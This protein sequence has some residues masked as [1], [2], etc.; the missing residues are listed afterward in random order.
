MKAATAYFGLRRHVAWMKSARELTREKLQSDLPFVYASHRTPMLRRLSGLDMR[1]QE[2]KV[3]NL[4][5]AAGCLDGLILRPGM[6][7]SFWY[8]VGKHI[9]VENLH[10]GGE[11]ELSLNFAGNYGFMC[12]PC[13]GAKWIF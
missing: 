8:N 4:K 12:N 2:N 5:I 13:I 11:V 3:T 9:G 10:L 1:L 7:F 6:T